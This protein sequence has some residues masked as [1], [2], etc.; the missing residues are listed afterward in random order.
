MSLLTAET[1]DEVYGA[2]A[3]AGA[4]PVT[5][6]AVGVGDQVRV[7]REERLVPVVHAR[8]RVRRSR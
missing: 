3:A 7:G 1:A 8:R 5:L 6:G 4:R 2:S